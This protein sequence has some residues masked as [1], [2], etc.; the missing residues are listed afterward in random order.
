MAGTNQS[1]LFRLSSP[2][3]TIGKAVTN[4]NNL[5]LLQVINQGGKVVHKVDFS[6]TAS[7]N[8]ATFTSDALLG[9]FFGSSFAAAFTNL[10]GED[11]IQV[12]K[13]PSGT[14]DGATSYYLDSTGASHNT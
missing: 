14:L 12:I 4:P 13:E 2:D 5:D 11:V 1:V 7:A 6:G 3:G 8:P 9:K 10:D